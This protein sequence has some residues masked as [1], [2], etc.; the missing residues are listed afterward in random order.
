MDH[1]DAQMTEVLV[2]LNG[3]YEG[4]LAEGVAL[5]TAAGLTVDETDDDNCT[6]HGTVESYRLAEIEKAPCVHFVRTILTYIADYPT[7]DPRD[8]DGT[9][10]ADDE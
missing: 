5:L 9:E 8:R 2:V 4:K 6:V 1:I 3:N 10:D 7:G